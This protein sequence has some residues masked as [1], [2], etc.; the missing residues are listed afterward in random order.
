[1]IYLDHHAAAPLS[2]AVRAAMADAHV[3]AWANP[4]SVHA[5]GRAAKAALERARRQVAQAIAA[6]PA[7]L[8]F[9]AGG[10]EACNLA[11][12]GLAGSTGPGALL[13][14]SIEHPGIARACEEL[15]TRGRPRRILDVPRGI[16]PGVEAFRAL[17]SGTVA[18]AALQWVNHETGTVL[19]VAEYAAACAG[20][21]VPLVVDASQAVGKLSVSVRSLAA[22]VLV[23]SGTKLGG[24]AGAAA[25]WVER[26]RELA[27]LLHG[28]MQERGRRPG[29]PDLAA[30]VGFGAAAEQVPDM[31]ADR[32]RIAALRDRLE[33]ACLS[34]G[35][36]VNGADGPRV[37]TVSNVSV[38]GWRGDQLVAA[39]DIEGLCASSG[40]ACSS[41]LGEP[42]KV[43]QAMYPDEPWRAESALRLSL[44]PATSEADVEAA[45]AILKRVIPRSRRA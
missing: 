37:A 39:L 15:A 29:T 44:G 35:A 25:L 18:V 14:T 12:F 40:A 5:A 16:P 19:P 43:L 17:L 38:P 41:G 30:L 22:A 2:A 45:I 28:G 33:S 3:H 8:V 6:E 11:L 7:D 4:S 34:L 42:S 1:M 13:T 36:V 10:T 21:G 20:A 24:P 26:G 9:A 23:V 31:I 32:P 27:P